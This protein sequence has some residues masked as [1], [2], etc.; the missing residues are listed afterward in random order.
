VACTAAISAPAQAASTACKAG[1][2]GYSSLP[3]SA[4]LSGSLC[5]TGGINGAGSCPGGP[6]VTTSIPWWSSPV[7]H[8]VR[9]TD[10]CYHISAYGG[11]ESMW[12]NIVVAVTDPADGLTIDETVWLRIAMNSE[13]QVHTSAG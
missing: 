5:D 10:G 3:F 7:V 4:G 9:I 8:V 1:G 13:G 6:H 12:A 11:A 2:V